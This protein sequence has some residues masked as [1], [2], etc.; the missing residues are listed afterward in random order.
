[1]CWTIVINVYNLYINRRQT[2]ILIWNCVTGASF[3]VPIQSN[4]PYG[5]T[6]YLQYQTNKTPSLNNRP[7]WMMPPGACRIVMITLN[8]LQTKSYGLQMRLYLYLQHQHWHPPTTSQLPQAC[9]RIKIRLISPSIIRPGSCHLL[10]QICSGRWFWIDSNHHPYLD[11]TC[12]FL[13]DLNCCSWL[14]WTRWY[15]ID[16]T[17]NSWLDLN[18]HF[19][20]D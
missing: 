4:I 7:V 13:I 17:H 3:Y 6:V 2:K 10:Q 12:L 11:S 14:D 1:M 18:H 20:L 15:Q 9:R 5:Q 16:W 8:H 19:W